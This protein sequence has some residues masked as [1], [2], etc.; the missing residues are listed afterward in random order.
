MNDD[1]NPKQ[2]NDGNRK[3]PSPDASQGSSESS[4]TG[5]YRGQYHH[6]DPARI[7]E[8]LSDSLNLALTS[9]NLETSESRFELARE[10]F[11]E[12]SERLLPDQAFDG[13]KENF[14]RAAL[15]FPT[16]HRTNAIKR[17]LGL[18][19]NAKRAGT[20]LKYLQEAQRIA[21]EGLNDPTARKDE[22]ES[23]FA[24]VS[25]RVLLVK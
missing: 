6:A 23:L 13:L 9:Q 24:I 5:R 21:R 17:L 4:H 18:S 10:C 15:A 14:A 16:V 22:L 11:R 20:K 19:E 8:I 3:A 7:Q 25:K 12:L 2:P 1:S